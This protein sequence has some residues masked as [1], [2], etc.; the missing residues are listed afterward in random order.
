M[1]LKLPLSFAS[2]LFGMNYA[3]MLDDV[4]G[5]S[6]SLWITLGFTLCSVGALLLPLV[7]NQRML[8]IVSAMFKLAFN[9]LLIR[10]G[11]YSIWMALDKDSGDLIAMV[12]EKIQ[13]MKSEVMRDQNEAKT[14]LIEEIPKR[15]DDEG[16]FSNSSF[17]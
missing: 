2:S 9:W 15:R 12:D 14:G 7:F 1:M 17:H 8:E 4:Q 3:P 16:Y 11:L 10:T 6:W 5:Q 13:K